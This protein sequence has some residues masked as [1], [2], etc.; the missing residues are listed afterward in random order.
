MHTW[1][2]KSHDQ[3]IIILNE[4]N[5][6]DKRTKLPRRDSGNRLGSHVN[7]LEQ[8]KSVPKFTHL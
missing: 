2:I 6:A 7:N 3:N 5:A 4:P 8:E 1:F